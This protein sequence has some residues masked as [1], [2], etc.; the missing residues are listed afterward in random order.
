MNGL[1]I[2]VNYKSDKYSVQFI[3]RYIELANKHI[4][5][6]VVDNSNSV[7][8]KSFID[9]TLQ[10]KLYY[11]QAK[12]NLGYFGAAKWLLTK[13][14]YDISDFIIIA[15]NDIRI[16]NENF[17]HILKQK[18]KIYDII[19]PSITTVDEI[20]QNPHRDKPYTFRRNILY[21]IYFS[22]YLIAKLISK[23]STFRKHLPKNKRDINQEEREIFSPHG[24]FII[25]SKSYFEKKGYIEDGY[26]LFGEE[27]SIAA[28]AQKN[29][30]KIGFVPQLKILHFESKSMDKGLSKSKYNF[31]K[32]AN[33]YINS[34]YPE[35][36]KNSN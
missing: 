22:N 16:L 14:D 13:I 9:S 3:K 26:F 19:A 36:F 11:F 1:I 32:K 27:D 7:E 24:A 28:I 2:I 33:K 25:L 10:P 17:F 29:K 18:L 8:L 15:N 31:Q 4:S 6:Y 21:K 5:L 20:E 35:L 23:I 30:M 34:K 12:K